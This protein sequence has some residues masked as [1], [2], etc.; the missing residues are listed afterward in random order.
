MKKWLLGLTLLAVIGAGTLY[1]SAMREVALVVDTAPAAANTA[2]VQQGA[3]IARTA[4]CIGC[5]TTRG[6]AAFAGG[7]GIATPFG[8]IY[9]S[10]LT[11]DQK[12]GIG[13]WTAAEFW[14]AMHHGQS[15]DGRL[16]YPAFPYTSYTNMSRADS[17]ALF[18]YLRSQT[19]VTHVNRA[20]E[21]RFPYGL[22]VSLGVWRTLYFTPGSSVAEP[23]RDAQ[24]QRG[25]YLVR[26]AGHCGA[27]HTPRDSLAG[28][29]NSRELQGAMMLAQSWYAPTLAGL[30]DVDIVQLL[31][32][33]H[34]GQRFVSGPMAEI[35]HGSTQYLDDADAQAISVFLKSLPPA[36]AA[37]NAPALSVTS[38][39][40][41]EAGGKIYEQH[42]VSCHGADGK[43]IKGAY[44]P[45]AGSRAVLAANPA[46]LAQMTLNGGFAVSTASN[47]RPFGMP[48]FAPLLNDAEVAAVLTYIRTAWGNQAGA[49]SE[50]QVR[51][52]P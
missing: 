25:A 18:A 13:S 38:Q 6:G 3:Y 23:G 33:G 27:C 47:A 22:Q 26:G 41:A 15:K 21:L 12:T 36:P 10:N 52:T 17:D 11:P 46:N 40:M 7:L 49:V 5:H 9:S 43:G 48:P 32:A 34:D 24:W 39:A 8:T 37:S 42:C 44:P 30:H 4:N 51:R 31:K 20:H 14:R 35:V 29:D 19:P 28:S 2:T 50:L 16:L 1:R 45:L